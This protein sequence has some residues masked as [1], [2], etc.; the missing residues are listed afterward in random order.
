MR[1][2]FTGFPSRKSSPK[3]AETTP[4]PIQT[5]ELC[6][7]CVGACCRNVRF[8]NLTPDELSTAFPNA[9]RVATYDE[10]YDALEFGGTATPD[11]VLFAPL[12]N[13]II[14]AAV[15]GKC[16]NLTPQNTC[17]IYTQR[18]T[19]CAEFPEGGKSCAKT[20]RSYRLETPNVT[21]IPLTEVKPPR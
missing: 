4:T 19:E 3:P 12:E 8:R 15:I 11:Y 13:G 20:R 18:P 16:P 17:N 9:T 14:A 10:A 2:F 21:I 7:S 6:H 5:G 1:E